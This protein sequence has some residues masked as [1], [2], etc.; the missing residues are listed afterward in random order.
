MP[1]KFEFEGEVYNLPTKRGLMF[2]SLAAN[3]QFIVRSEYPIWDHGVQIGKQ[4]DIVAEFGDPN[5]PMLHDEDTGDDYVVTRGHYC[6][7]AEQARAKG[8]TPDEQALAEKRL[9]TSQSPGLHWLHA[10][11]KFPAPWP[12]YDVTPEE[13][14]P[15]LAASLGLINE[16]NAYEAQ[17]LARESVLDALSKIEAPAEPEPIEA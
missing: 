11:P 6:Q 4:R 10:E 14:I 7:T 15:V 1:E 13:E 17:N 3:Y 12:R 5:A 8:W 16:A 2:Q 9:L